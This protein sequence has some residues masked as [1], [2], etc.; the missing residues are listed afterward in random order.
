MLA[1]HSVTMIPYRNKL[2]RRDKLRSWWG[3]HLVL[4]L[5]A[6]C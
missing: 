5:L 2:L 4:S 3:N 1:K 6:Q